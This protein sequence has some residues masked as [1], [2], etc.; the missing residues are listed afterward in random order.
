MDVDLVLEGGGVKGIGLV[1]AYAVLRE[2]GFSVR[3]VAG[4]SAGAVVGALV[5]ADLP[6]R[7][8]VR[9]MRDVDYRKFR[10]RGLLDR[11]G[12][13]GEVASV[14]FEKGVYEGEYLRTWLDGILAGRGKR[15]FGDLRI[16]DPSLPPNR[17]Y[18]LVVLA[19]D[20]SRGRLVRLPWDYPEYGLVADDQLV[21]DA[22]R[23]SMSIPFFFEPAQLRATGRPTATSYVVD[24]GLMSLYPIDVFTSTDPTPLR[25]TIGVKLSGR[26]DPKQVH[27]FPIHNTIEFAVAMVE[28]M[29]TWYDNLH[30]DDDHAIA[31]TVFV[32]TT[33]VRATEFDLSE[34]KRDL[35]YRNGRK[36]ARKFL[37]SWQPPAA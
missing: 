26:P 10:D 33:G 36:A 23:A 22:V 28:S 2:R 6:L 4:T 7:K 24:G 11:L 5:A 13:I 29:V 19:A 21:A 27:M 15:T 35:L 20:V 25:P 37:A 31:N 30:I 17:R 12:P 14:L 32:D 9:T 18:R 16:D 8:L 1:G 34:T 3:R